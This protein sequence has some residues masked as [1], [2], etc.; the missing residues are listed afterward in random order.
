M[1]RVEAAGGQVLAIDTGRVTGESAGQWLSGTM[2][3]A[4]AEYTRRTI[5]ERIAGGIVDAIGR[6][7]PPWNGVTAGYR[8]LA[9]STWEPDPVNAPIV[10]R[11]FELRAE[12]ATL[13][14]VQ[15]FLTANGITLSYPGVRKLLL[16]RHVLGELHFGS[17]EPNLRAWLPIVD[18]DLWSAVQ[19]ANRPAG[20]PATRGERLLARVGVLRCGSCGARMSVNNHKGSYYRCGAHRGSATRG[21]RVGAELVEAY[22]V[23]KVRERLADA[24]GAARATR[25]GRRSSARLRSRRPR[26]TVPSVR[27]RRSGQSPRLS[28]R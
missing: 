21:P 23:G 7:V 16:S 3:G 27:S 25:H 4:V 13:Q 24:A 20:R 10:V 1:Q 15:T 9:D 8:K 12:G 28:R 17:F 5:G 6:G 19:R 22:V 14:E 26:S 2:L 18:V 11:A